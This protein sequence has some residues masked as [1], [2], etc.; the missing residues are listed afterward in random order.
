M[1]KPDDENM[2]EKMSKV[3]HSRLGPVLEDLAM[4]LRLSFDA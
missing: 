4:I 1:R 2:K 3:L